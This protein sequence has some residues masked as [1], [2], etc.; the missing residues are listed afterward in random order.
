MDILN[1][2]LVVYEFKVDERQMFIYT[3]MDLRNM[4]Q[5][6]QDWLKTHID[7]VNRLNVFPVPDGDTGTNMWLTMRAATENVER[8][9]NNEAGTVALGAAQG[10]LMGA[11]GN[12]GVILSQFL[13]G[14]AVGLANLT[15]F[16]TRDFAHA[17][18][19]G[20][21]MAYKSVSE[22]I[23]GTIL[24]VARAAAEA[25]KHSS[26]IN[27]D[28]LL[29]L[30]ET[31]K[32]AKIAEANTPSLLPI[33]R[34]AGVTDSG[35]QGLVCILEGALRFL[36]GQPVDA[37]TDEANI[38]P[39]QSDLGTLETDFGY[40]VQFLIHGEQ[41]DVEDIRQHI[42]AIGWSTLVVG[43]TQTVKVHVHV[44]DPGVPLSYGVTKGSLADVVVEDMQAQAKDFVRENSQKS[45]APHLTVWPDGMGTTISTVAI[46]PGK[47]LAHIFQSLGVS[48][49]LSGGQTMNPST[50]ELLNAIGKANT[51]D[52][53]V[54]PN[55]SNV[56]LAAQQAKKL[57][58]KN[59]QII[60]T[61]TIPQGI[62]ALLSFNHQA[63]LETNIQQMMHASRQIQTIEV[64]QSV[65]D[66]TL[67]GLQIKFGDIIGLFNGELV[68]VG[69][70]FDSVT[71]DVIARKIKPEN[72][73][74]VT[75]YFGQDIS[76]EQAEALAKQIDT[77]YPNLEVEVH[78]GGQPHYYYIIS[79]E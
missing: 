67:S 59:V 44:C 27:Q 7:L 25:A 21:D 29:V 33:L 41:L 43:N 69:Q 4:L 32:A 16:T 3:G 64:T 9:T 28:L 51:N 17:T 66:T 35:G 18:Q 55:N 10:A 22:P 53:L 72:L 13:Q 19:L 65:R 62:A 11:R 26:E 70:D 15:T 50:Q 34:E 56:I 60:P 8:V 2:T 46:V 68:S 71:L 54:L 5:A 63:N 61:K 31:V 45:T 76:H 57:A 30:L 20:A 12:S 38:Q 58:S 1:E 36:N 49:V 75:I 48:Q 40:D 42:N 79:L 78:D 39:L 52:V 77:H 14:I 23:E 73:E 74:V 24:T 37:D 47:G 6:G